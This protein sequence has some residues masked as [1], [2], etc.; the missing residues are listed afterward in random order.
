MK[1]TPGVCALALSYRLSFWRAAQKNRQALLLDG[2]S[3]QLISYLFFMFS[4]GAWAEAIA[5]GKVG[6]AV[7]LAGKAQGDSNCSIHHSKMY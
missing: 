4:E 2:M 7:P 6:Q 1:L 5:L 3:C